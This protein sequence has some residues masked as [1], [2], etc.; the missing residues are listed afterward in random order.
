MSLRQIAQH[1]GISAMTVQR[2]VKRGPNSLSKDLNA[3]QLDA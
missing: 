2:R 3:A 1:L